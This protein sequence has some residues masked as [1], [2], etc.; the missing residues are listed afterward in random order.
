MPNG[1]LA[2]ETN[3]LTDALRQKLAAKTFRTVLEYDEAISSYFD[4]HLLVSDAPKKIS[5]SYGENPGQEAFLLQTKNKEEPITHLYGKELSYN[6][7]LDFRANLLK[8]E[9]KQIK[10]FFFVNPSGNMPLFF[11]S[12]FVPL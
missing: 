5:L 11:R 7:I 12:F 3:S 6:N 8:S 9:F 10:T 2:I 1:I 4:Q